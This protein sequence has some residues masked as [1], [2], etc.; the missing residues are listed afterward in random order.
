[1]TIKRKIQEVK[2]GHRLSFFLLPCIL[3][4]VCVSAFASNSETSGVGVKDLV[5]KAIAAH[6]F[7]NGGNSK[8]RSW[9]VV[10]DA[11]L[12]I[13]GKEVECRL[14]ISIEPPDRGHMKLQFEHEGKGVTVLSIYDGKSAE[15]WNSV[16]YTHLTL[17]TKA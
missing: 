16:S 3:G 4:L 14:T 10:Q 9:V 11:N 7:A 8:A 5:K 2:T 13:G 6:G 12:T 15:G 17:P 1:M